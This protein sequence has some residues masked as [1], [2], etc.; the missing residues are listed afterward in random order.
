MDILSDYLQ[1]LY[2][3]EPLST[4]EE[5]ALAARIKRVTKKH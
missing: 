2:G 5:H 1:S 4:E 3:I